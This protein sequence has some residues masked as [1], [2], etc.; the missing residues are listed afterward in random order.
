MHARAATTAATRAPF[1]NGS[2]RSSDDFAVPAPLARW[3]GADSAETFATPPG[4]VGSLGERMDMIVAFR[5]NR[6]RNRRKAWA[7]FMNGRG[8]TQAGNETRARDAPESQTGALVAR[9]Q[10]SRI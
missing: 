10:I 6:D 9:D 2:N 8:I 5:R 4:V 1:R 3:S 7:Q